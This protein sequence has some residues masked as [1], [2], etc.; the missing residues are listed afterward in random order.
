MLAIAIMLEIIAFAAIFGLGGLGLG[1]AVLGITLFLLT[2]T[3]LMERREARLAGS[4][5]RGTC[6]ALKNRLNP[7][8]VARDII[9]P[10]HSRQLFSLETRFNIRRFGSAWDQN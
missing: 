9:P 10:R 1:F 3:I 4:L 2:G 7:R 6:Y 8:T 5:G